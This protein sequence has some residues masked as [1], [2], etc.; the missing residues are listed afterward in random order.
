M[1]VHRVASTSSKARDTEGKTIN[2]KK[3]DFLLF[4]GQQRMTAILLGFGKGQMKDSCKL[5]VDFGG[6]KKNPKLKF[7]LRITSTGQPFGYRPDL[8]NQKIKLG[9]RHE[10]WANIL[11]KDP[12]LKPQEVFKA[13][14]N[15][16][17]IIDAECPVSFHD[18]CALTLLDENKLERAI[19]EL[20]KE[21]NAPKAEACIKEFVCAL[22]KST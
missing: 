18:I 16:S 10:K 19:G 22:K 15:G 9:K 5:W 20:A 3:D 2:A 12:N 14:V 8:P 17:Y 6:S 1:M 4:D 21:K 11:E 13:D 7:Q